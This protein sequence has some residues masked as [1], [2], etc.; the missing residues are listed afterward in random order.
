MD[1]TSLLKLIVQKIVFATKRDNLKLPT[2][3][4]C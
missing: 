1:K 2:P 3:T 4:I